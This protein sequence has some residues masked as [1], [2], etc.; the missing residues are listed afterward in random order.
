MEILLQGLVSSMHQLQLFTT[1]QTC[2]GLKI[3]VIGKVGFLLFCFAWFACC[4]G[5][6]YW[7][8]D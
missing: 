4:F 6:F 1:A 3:T 8:C 5:Y 2:E 7:S